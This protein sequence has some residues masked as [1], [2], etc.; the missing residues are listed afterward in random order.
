MAAVYVKNMD[1]TDG[2][3]LQSST[4]CCVARPADCLTCVRDLPHFVQ[5]TVQPGTAL[6]SGR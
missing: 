4:M 5:P 3:V 1:K 6:G 2:A